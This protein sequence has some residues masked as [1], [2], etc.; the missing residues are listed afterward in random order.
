MIVKKLLLYVNN[1]MMKWN[2]K[3]KINTIVHYNKYNVKYVIINTN[4]MKN[5]YIYNNILL[6][7]KI[8]NIM[9]YYL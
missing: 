9:K 5:N 1:V 8:I 6:N 2:V 3:R 4:K 7:I